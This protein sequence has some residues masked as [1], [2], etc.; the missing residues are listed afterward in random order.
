MKLSAARPL[1]QDMQDSV[2]LMNEVDIKTQ[3]QLFDIIK[4]HIPPQQQ[5]PKVKYFT[6]EAFE[7]YQEKHCKM[8]KKTEPTNEA[9]PVKKKP[10]KK[11]RGN[12]R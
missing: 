3:E 12:E 5:T 6:I 9:T 4:K 2:F 1:T 7:K 10:Q 8:L 11:R